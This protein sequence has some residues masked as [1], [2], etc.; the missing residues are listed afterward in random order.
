MKIK[1]RKQLKKTNEELMQRLSL[2]S[3]TIAQIGLDKREMY[4]GPNEFIISRGNEYWGKMH[5]IFDGKDITDSVTKIM[6]HGPKFISEQKS[7]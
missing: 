3:M 2:Y 6:I 4:M 7:L 5:I 1:T